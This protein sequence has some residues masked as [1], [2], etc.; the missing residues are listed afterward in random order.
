MTSPF[1]LGYFA[2]CI[3]QGGIIAYPT[4]TIYGLGCDPQQEIAVSHLLAMKRRPI[5]KG[6]IM[7]AADIAQILPYVDVSLA[8]LTPSLSAVD[9][10]TTWLLPKSGQTP[11]WISGQYATIAIRL[12]QHPVAAALCRQLGHPLVS[13]SANLNRQAPAHN[14]L[15]IQKKFRTQLSGLL[16]GRTLTNA[17]SEIKDWRSGAIVRSA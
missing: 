15:H 10:P 13:T 8:D 2:H 16:H 7:I 1:K 3:R 14:P 4:E 12:T 9:H 17:P 11:Y 6:L 5:E